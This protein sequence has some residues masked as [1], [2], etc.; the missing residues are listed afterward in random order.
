MGGV[1]VGFGVRVDVEPVGPVDLVVGVVVGPSVVDAAVTSVPVH[2]EARAHRQ[3][4][5]TIEVTT[6]RSPIMRIMLA[7]GT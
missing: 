7:A 2:P 6:N 1:R 3:T 4:P 5:V